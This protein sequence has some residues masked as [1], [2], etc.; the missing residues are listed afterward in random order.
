[1]HFIGHIR[2][3]FD[4]TILLIEHDMK[5]VMGVCVHLGHGIRRPYPHRGLSGR[6]PQQSPLLSG[7]YLGEDMVKQ[8]A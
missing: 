8:N 6:N 5:V 7:A 2:D 1:M 4:P 3:E